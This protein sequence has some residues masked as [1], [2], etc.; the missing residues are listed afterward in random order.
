MCLIFPVS[1]FEE[2]HEIIHIHG[3][4]TTDRTLHVIFGNLLE[5]HIFWGISSKHCVFT[6][7]YGWAE[8]MCSEQRTWGR[9]CWLREVPRHSGGLNDPPGKGAGSGGTDPRVSGTRF[10]FTSE[11]QQ[12]HFCT[13]KRFPGHTEDPEPRDRAAAGRKRE[14]MTRPAVLPHTLKQTAYEKGG[15]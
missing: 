15:V 8:R 13:R 11:H 7:G 9:N 4:D 14:K 12:N 2:K 5:M 10:L 6:F 1:F 3:S